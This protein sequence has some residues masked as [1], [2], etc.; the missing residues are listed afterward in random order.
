M[1][2]QILKNTQLLSNKLTDNSSILWFY[3]IFNVN[4]MLI[5]NISI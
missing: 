5:L 3:F 1:S 2:K 4:V